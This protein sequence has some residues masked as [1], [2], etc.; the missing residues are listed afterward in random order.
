[1]TATV[2]STEI[3]TRPANPP[4]SLGRPVTVTFY[5]YLLRFWGITRKLT[6]MH[7]ANYYTARG[8]RNTR[9]GKKKMPRNNPK[10]PS[11]AIPTIRNGN[12]ISHTK[13]YRIS[14]SKASGQHKISSRHHSRKEAI[15]SLL[16]PFSTQ[17]N[18][19]M[20]LHGIFFKL[21][22]PHH[23]RRNFSL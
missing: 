3:S 5:T 9:A 7:F 17:R 13:G 14:A 1:M 15:A 20:F 18:A 6:P 10:T 22:P 16:L 23:R 12:R 11:T 2:L 21:Q 19:R 8:P 4:A